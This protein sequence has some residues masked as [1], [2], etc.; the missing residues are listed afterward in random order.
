M[1][2]HIFTGFGFG[3]IQSGLFV[4]EAFDS[5]NFSRIVIAEIDQ[6]LVDAVRQSGG[7]YYVN[8]ATSNSIE[9]QQIDN[10]E[11][12][13]P[14]VP[15]DKEKLIEA[16]AQSTEISTSLP[17]VNF[18]DTGDNS[19]VKLLKQG[20]DKSQTAKIIYTAENNNHA[21]EILEQKVGTF[22]N[23]QFLN[24]VIGKMSQVVN[25]PEQIKEKN[26]KTVV[27]GFQRAFL[28]EEFSKIMV[29]K[30]N[31]PG[32]NPGIEIFSEKTDLLPFEEAKLYGHNAIH[33]LLSFLGAYKGYNNMSQLSDD[34][35]LMQIAR[36]A[37]IEE[38]GK[39]LVKKYKHLGDELFTPE[40]FHVYA[41][42]L[43]ARMTNPFL[44]DAIERTARD[45]IR[46]LGL[47]DRIFGTMQLALD[48][49]IE[50]VN[51]AKGA[52]AGLWYL[53]QDQAWDCQKSKY[54]DQIKKL[55]LGDL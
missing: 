16:I 36:E 19:V 18:Y 50:P 22:D 23:V 15:Q 52:R 6:N 9:V 2:K 47:N 31:L 53:L 14:N 35:Q 4:A 34:K 40:G 43:L 41:E 8:V 39:A 5:G 46:K 51:M 42:D 17:S 1:T 32:F 13:N 38:S 12:Y 29:T 21:A 10:I 3:P 37:F 30:C 44:A 48:N 26:L 55:V 33:A 45:P 49:G 25:D 11:I 20:L 28:V 24:T 27:N 7:T 54:S